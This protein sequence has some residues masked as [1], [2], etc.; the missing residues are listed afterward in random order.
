MALIHLKMN[1]D[2]YNRFANFAIALTIGTLMAVMIGLI[3]IRKGTGWEDIAY[4]YMTLFGAS[5]MGIGSIIFSASALKGGTQKK[6]KAMLG[7]YLPLFAITVLL[8]VKF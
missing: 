4:F 1:T 2:R 5:I 8:M 6:G 7:I 3:L